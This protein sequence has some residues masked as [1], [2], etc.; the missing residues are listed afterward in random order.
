MDLQQAQQNDDDLRPVIA[1]LK[2]SIDRPSWED[3]APL[4]S[5]TKAYW[6]QWSSL[7]LVDGVLYRLW[8]TPE[9]DKCFQPIGVSK[10]LRETILRELHSTITA[11]HFGLG[12]LPT[13]HPRLVPQV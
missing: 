13:G 3:V 6:A 11:G 2:A 4:G 8:E 5:C 12:E 9:G 7:Q 1:W 10:A